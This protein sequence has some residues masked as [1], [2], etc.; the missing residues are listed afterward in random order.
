MVFV[1]ALGVLLFGCAG[2]EPAKNTIAQGIQPAQTQPD[3]GAGQ[4]QAKEFAVKAFRFGYAPDEIKVNKGDRVKITIENTDT[5]HGIRIPDLGIR[6][7]ETIDFVAEKQGE[8]TWYCNVMC[9][10]G[11][12]EMKGK[13]VVE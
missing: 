10:P 13:L 1:L 6:E 4:P 8:F 9:G 11:H 3:S 5:M 7:N 2:N 12:M